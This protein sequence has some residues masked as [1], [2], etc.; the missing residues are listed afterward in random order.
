MSQFD[1]NEGSRK[2]PGSP[3]RH[4]CFGSL[5]IWSGLV[6]AIL[7]LAAAAL[8]MIPPLIGLFDNDQS[9][10]SQQPV[11]SGSSNMPTSDSNAPQPTPPATESTQP[12]PHPG[13]VPD[14]FLG[15]WVG[16]VTDGS[17]YSPYPV[18]IIVTPGSLGKRAGTSE[19]VTLKCSGY[20]IL[21]S[22]KDD[23]LVMQ[24][25]IQSGNC[26][27]TL[28]LT[29]QVNSDGSLEYGFT[30]SWGEGAA[31]LHKET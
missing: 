7:G 10:P 23:E 24:E 13:T 27:N 12:T 14:R 17:P 8:G 20:L 16:S 18:R 28:L 22:V 6:I 11:G 9:P 15:T 3:Q 29:L 5:L 26:V 21:S 19:Y 2:I 31:I 1:P 30:S 25:N 4:G